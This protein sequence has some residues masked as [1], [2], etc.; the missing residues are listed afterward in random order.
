MS[1]EKCPSCE[2]H[3]YKCNFSDCKRNNDGHCKIYTSD[4]I[5]RPSDGGYGMRIADH[6]KLN[7]KCFGYEKEDQP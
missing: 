4:E 2:E 6:I 3:A 1:K 5:Y 7:G